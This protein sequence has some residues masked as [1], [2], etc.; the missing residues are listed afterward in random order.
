LKIYNVKIETPSF[1]VLWKKVDNWCPT[2][3]KCHEMWP[4]KLFALFLLSQVP[5]VYIYATQ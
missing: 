1:V 2:L 5:W 4:M 3:G